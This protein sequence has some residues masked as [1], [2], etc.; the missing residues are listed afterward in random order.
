MDKNDSKLHSSLDVLSELY[1]TEELIQDLVEKEQFGRLS[2][3]LLKETGVFTSIVAGCQKGT[4]ISEILP[5][6][7]AICAGLLMRM[8]KFMQAIAKL[9]TESGFGAVIQSMF[10]SVVESA[11][12]IIFFTM[13]DSKDLYDNYVRC[14]L[15]AERAL[16]DN[17]QKNISDRGGVIQPIED[18]MLTS[19]D[20]TCSDSG[21][22]IEDINPS[23]RDWG[24]PGGFKKRIETVGFGEGYIGLFRTASH[25]VHGTWGD[26][27]VNYLSAKGN[28]FVVR[29]EFKS[30]DTRVILPICLFAVDAMRSYLLKFVGSASEV[31]GFH[32][33]LSDLRKRL[34]K[35]DTA[36]EIWIQ[37]KHID[38]GT[39]P[40]PPK[41]D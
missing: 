7:Q 1:V 41:P 25:F 13:Q 18:R 16:Y 36:H 10:R 19:I 35:S 21:M 5:R 24:P 12:N 34:L 29:E 2:F 4:A 15:S 33:G 8:T 20:K 22:R 23:Y 17:I 9:S 28:G 30:G 14:G 6:D 31:P 40:A 37:S 32:Q 39:K 3:E 11:V 27:I 26:L 38:M